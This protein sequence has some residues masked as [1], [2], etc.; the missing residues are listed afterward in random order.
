MGKLNLT[1]FNICGRR[2]LFCGVCG[3]FCLRYP[4]QEARGA[5]CIRSSRVISCFLSFILSISYF[6][7]P[8]TENRKIDLERETRDDLFL[9]PKLHFLINTVPINIKIYVPIF[10]YSISKDSQ[11]P[12][13]QALNKSFSVLMFIYRHFVIVQNKSYALKKR[14]EHVFTLI[15]EIMYDVF[16]R[17]ISQQGRTKFCEYAK[18]VAR[19]QLIEKNAGRE[20]EA[21]G[22]YVSAGQE[23]RTQMHLTRARVIRCFPASNGL[24]APAAVSGKRGM[25]PTYAKRELCLCIRISSTGLRH[26]VAVMQ[27]W[28]KWRLPQFEETMSVKTETRR[29]LNSRSTLRKFCTDKPDIMYEVTHE[30]YIL[31]FIRFSFQDKKDRKGEIYIYFFKTNLSGDILFLF[32][33]LR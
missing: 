31:Y 28:T 29:W 33:Y 30:I 5:R 26:Y 18:S 9:D 25:K 3:I 6:C 2:A 11:L 22:D 20:C 19:K 21:A 15:K 8:R 23:L 4:L 13:A 27:N 17:L 32:N 10:R 1:S 16:F 12:S 24:N 7:L 14:V